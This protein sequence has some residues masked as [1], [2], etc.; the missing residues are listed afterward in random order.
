MQAEMTP[1]LVADALVM[2]M[3]R[4]NLDFS[5]IILT[6]VRNPPEKSSNDCCAR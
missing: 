6:P 3:A 5:S 4:T 1:Q 2:A